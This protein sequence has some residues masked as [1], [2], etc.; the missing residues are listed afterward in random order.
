MLVARRAFFSF[1]CLAVHPENDGREDEKKR[2]EKV[3]A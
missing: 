1:K 3:E 2:R